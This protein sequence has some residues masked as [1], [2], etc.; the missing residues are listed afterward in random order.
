M[1]KARVV[2]L[3]GKA[4]NFDIELKRD[5]SGWWS[6]DVPPDM[7]D[8]QYAVEL[9]AINEY[10]E[11][12]YWTGELFMCSGVCHL[13]IKEQK[14]VIWFQPK[15]FEIKFQQPKFEMIIRKGCPHDMRRQNRILCR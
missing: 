6:C 14:F 13:E 9:H 11:S 3:Y 8:G 15:K 7:S 10:G 12:A 5:E 4:D 1:S 2:R